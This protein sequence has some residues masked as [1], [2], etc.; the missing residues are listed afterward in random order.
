M[1]VFFQLHIKIIIVIFTIKFIITLSLVVCIFIPSIILLVFIVRSVEVEALRLTIYCIPTHLE[2]MSIALKKLKLTYI[3]STDVNLKCVG[4]I[5]LAE[6]TEISD[7]MIS[8]IESL[9][10]NEL[11]KE[12]KTIP[13]SD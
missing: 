1:Q 4:L 8:M 9:Y 3:Y 7:S 2:I 10:G 6:A 5:L 11:I 12:V 13:N